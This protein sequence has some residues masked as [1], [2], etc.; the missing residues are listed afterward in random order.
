MRRRLL[1]LAA[2][3]ACLTPLLA[4]CSSGGFTVTASFEDVGDL[5]SRGGVQVADVRVG[6]IKS[7]KLTEGF[8]A[9]VRI[10][11]NNGVRV[12][13]ESQ[14]LIRTTS[15]LGEKFVELRP[16]GDPAT[17]PFL[18]DGDVITDAGEAPELEFVA[19]QA[20]DVLGSITAND[21]STL[22]QTGAEGFGGRESD[23]RSL[24]E[25]FTT[26]SHTFA[27][28]TKTIQ[29]LIDGLDRTSSTLAQGSGDLATLLDNLVTTT[30]I[31]ADNRDRAVTALDKL[32]RLARVQNRTLDKYRV[33]IDR[34]IKQLNA[35]VAIA[36]QNT[37]SVSL[38][39]DWLDRFMAATPTVIPG[40]F[41]Q[42][43]MWA[44]PCDQDPRTQKPCPPPE[45]APSP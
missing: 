12:P 38:L 35:I 11:L 33:D 18:R 6:T 27:E 2:A 41:T 20:V 1:S 30:Q 15:L 43:Y 40:D 28:K 34:Q 24:I 29:S 5:Q 10:H 3:L 17:G 39:V 44:I 13:R 23:L 8:K 42:V 22:I 32:D 19:Q 45:Q 37:G 36:A 31:L 25:D 16:K 4:A 14:A 26:V 7:I 21:V 9:R